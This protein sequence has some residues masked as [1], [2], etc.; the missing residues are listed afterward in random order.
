ML[1]IRRTVAHFKYDTP[2]ATRFDEFA[3]WR[4][5]VPCNN[6]VSFR[7]HFF[8]EL[9]INEFPQTISIFRSADKILEFIHC[10]QLLAN[11]HLMCTPSSYST[12]ITEMRLRCQS[13][14]LIPLFSPIGA[15]RPATA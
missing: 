2:Q 8:Y 11:N 1:V 12:I 9:P 14:P 4:I 5:T 10:M 6:A 3:Q 15:A 13:T 7:R